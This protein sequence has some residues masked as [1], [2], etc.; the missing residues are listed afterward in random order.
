VVTSGF[1]SLALVARTCQYAAAR[2]LIMA[3]GGNTTPL[4]YREL[5]RWTT[6][7]LRAGDEVTQGR[8]M[9]CR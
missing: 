2:M 1:S 6:H 5:E 8:A 9:T 7:R 4:D 3:G